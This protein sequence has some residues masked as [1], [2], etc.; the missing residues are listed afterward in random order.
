[1]TELAGGIWLDL[2]AL[3]WFIGC[4]VG[5]TR[6]A[7]VQSATEVCLASVMHMYRV[8]WARA[9]LRRSNRIADISVIMTFERN[10][11]FLGSSSLI[12][13][14]GLL[15][16]LGNLDHA[17]VLLAGLPFSLDQSLLQWEAKISLL[18]VM[19]V[20]AFFKFTWAMRQ[21]GFAAILIGA[22]PDAEA[23]DV[24]EQ[25]Q[26]DAAERIGRVVSMAAH[27]F[28]FGM[29]TYY[30]ALAVLAWFINPWIFMCA[31]GLVVW[32]LYRRE[33]NSSVLRA[34]SA[35]RAA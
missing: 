3:V 20:Y 9:L 2:L 18:M 6:Y 33:F 16:V 27:H 24:S 15:T 26:R 5:Y 12:I 28:N 1:M 32:V 21:I 34:L 22:A 14:A 19:F 7:K 25:A 30:F 31:S 11:A 29:R 4:W 13:V 8:E 17:M 23:A 10:M 35:N